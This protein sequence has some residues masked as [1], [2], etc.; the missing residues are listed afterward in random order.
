M[1][2]CQKMRSNEVVFEWSLGVTEEKSFNNEED[3]TAYR[4]VEM[5]VKA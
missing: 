3:Y 2:Q 4:L 5:K 1:Q